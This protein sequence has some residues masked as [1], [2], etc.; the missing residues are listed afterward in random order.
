MSTEQEQP[1]VLDPWAVIR[2]EKITKQAWCS[3]LVRPAD[4]HRLLF[5]LKRTGREQGFDS[6]EMDYSRISHR[7]SHIPKDMICQQL[8][9]EIFYEPPKNDI[10]KMARSATQPLTMNESLLG[11]FQTGVLYYELSARVW[12]Q[13]LLS[14]FMP[15]GIQDWRTCEY[16]KGV[17]NYPENKRIKLSDGYNWHIVLVTGLWE[18][19]HPVHVRITLTY[20]EAI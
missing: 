12:N 14:S 19:I 13:H 15:S 10:E 2:D 18:P 11:C 9:L 4:K 16:F 7:L 8:S 5:F 3:A 1:V 17:I 20:S 6:D